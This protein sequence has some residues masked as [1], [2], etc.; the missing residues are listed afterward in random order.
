[1]KKRMFSLILCLMLMV[2]LTV[3]VFA[4]NE[5]GNYYD[6]TEELWNQTLEVLGTSTLPSMAEFYGL[7]IRV[8]VL[9][10][11]GANGVE[12]SAQQIYEEYGYG[13]GEGMD[14]VSLTVYAVADEEGWYVDSWTVY[15]GG[16]DPAWQGLE[17]TLTAAL[18]PAFADNLWSQGLNYDI[19]AMASAVALLSTGVSDFVANGPA[20]APANPVVPAA[21]VAPSAPEG[22]DF[23][24]AGNVIDLAG[25]LTAQEDETL[26]GVIA[27]I[28]DSYQCGCYIVTVND[29]YAY[30]SDAPDAVIN[31]YHDNGLGIGGDRDG[32]L[33]L[34][35]PMHR[36]F[37]FFV[38]GDN[39]SYIFDAYGQDMLEDVFL[40]DF[41]VDAWYD[42]FEDFVYECG[43]YME[44]AAQGNPV[45]E[46][47]AGGYGMAILV[48]LI[49]AAVVCFVLVGQ[50][51]SVFVGAEASAYVVD[52]TVVFTEKHDNFLYKTTT[53]RDLSSDDDDG[54]STSS[55]SGGGGSGRSGSF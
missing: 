22:I 45:R 25:V 35:D 46:S 23:S 7:D 43:E 8:D 12:A 44:L 48:A 6:E 24:A 20:D 28:S 4:A 39:A 1:M 50:M 18:A 54:G 15:V 38:Y 55:F 29:L 31:I 51:K 14:G 52:G 17:S 27:S 21:P 53:T 36:E 42:G 40:D 2:S 49:V 26:E 9:T 19:T 13:L 47:K 30:G 5:Y 37:A 10:S 32:I 34:M 41:S 16:S 11:V 33:L 3:P